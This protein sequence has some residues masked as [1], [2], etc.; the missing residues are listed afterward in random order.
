M[1]TDPPCDLNDSGKRFL[2][3]IP[4]SFFCFP[5][6][7][8]VVGVGGIRFFVKHTSFPPFFSNLQF[9]FAV[10]LQKDLQLDY[11][12]LFFL[13]LIFLAL[14]WESLGWLK[15]VTIGNVIGQVVVHGSTLKVMCRSSGF[16]DANNTFGEPPCP[17][18][19]SQK[20]YANLSCSAA[21]GESAPGWLD[22][23]Q[24]HVVV[25]SSRPVNAVQKCWHNAVLTVD[26]FSTPSSPADN[27]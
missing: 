24:H 7:S 5:S 26:S 23:A 25:S 10:W 20:H 15:K 2:S 19:S 11:G 21:H 1:K 18:I 13:E 12:K 6:F 27:H 4:R 17:A 9:G 8:F 14:I 3:S 16:G 22:T